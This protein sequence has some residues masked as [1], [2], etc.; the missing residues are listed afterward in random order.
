ME[1]QDAQEAAAMPDDAD[2]DDRTDFEAQLRKLTA[3]VENYTRRS[4]ERHQADREASG[5]R[6]DE[7]A[8]NA[9]VSSRI[10]AFEGKF[11]EFSE[12]ISHTMSELTEQMRRKVAL[13]SANEKLFDALHGE[14]KSYKEDTIV[15]TMQKPFLLDLIALRDNLALVLGQLDDA[16]GDNAGI[17][18]PR[19]NLDNSLHFLDEILARHSVEPIEVASERLDGRFQRAVEFRDVNDESLAGKVL[20]IKRCGYRWRGKVL[21]P[22]DVEVGRTSRSGSG[23]AGGQ[24]APEEPRD[25]G[26]Q[27]PDDQS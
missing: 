12:L 17:R 22:V 21:R 27:Q 8:T 25:A 19:E 26:R 16:Q 24:A 13:E 18:L 6:P 11:R 4:E 9:D 2:T 23:G 7:P 1:K 15:E 14:L 20:S 10:E 5:E 3:E